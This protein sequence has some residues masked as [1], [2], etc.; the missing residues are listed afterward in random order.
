MTGAPG[1][2]RREPAIAPDGWLE[3]LVTH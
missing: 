3:Y 1:D 2:A